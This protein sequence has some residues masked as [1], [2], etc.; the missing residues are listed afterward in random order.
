VQSHNEFH[1]PGWTT[2]VKEK[3]DAARQA[4]LAWLDVVKPKFGF[5]FDNMKRSRAIFKLALR[6]CKNHADQLKADACVENLLD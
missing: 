2:F 5:Y 3:H 4:N 6:Y 1:V